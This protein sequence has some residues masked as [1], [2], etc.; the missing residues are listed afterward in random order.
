MNREVPFTVRDG[1]ELPFVLRQIIFPIVVV[2]LSYR[3][4]IWGVPDGVLKIKSLPV[5]VGINDLWRG[6]RSNS[7]DLESRVHLPSKYSV[8]P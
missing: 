2:V 5:P 8:G 3:N 1:P 4:K 6:T 7:D